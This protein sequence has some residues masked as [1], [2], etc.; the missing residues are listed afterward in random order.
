MS[1]EASSLIESEALIEL[2]VVGAPFGVRGWV[3][4]RSHTEP[5]ERLL[6]H[7]NLQLRLGGNWRA[8]RID[9]SGRSGGQLTVKLAGVE[10]RDAAAALKGAMIGVPRSELPPREDKDFYRA[11]LIGCEVTNLKGE[12]LGVVSH[13]VEIPAH[14]LM[15][16]RGEK[17]YWV[18]AV[19]QHL[20]RV[21]LQARRIIVDWD[22]ATR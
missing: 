11:D 4:V 8:Y 1:G 20:R 21:D 18:P 17:E 3:K 13:F 19:P 9:A 12:R 16:V 14:A 5:P 10:D 15:V 22:A 2:G 7:R 6:E